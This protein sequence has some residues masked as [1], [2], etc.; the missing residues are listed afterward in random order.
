MLCQVPNYVFKLTDTFGRQ[1]RPA[2]R[3]LFVRRFAVERLTL[4]RKNSRQADLLVSCTGT[5]NGT[6]LG[7][8]SDAG[9]PDVN[10]EEALS[11]TTCAGKQ[12]K[13]AHT[14]DL[15][16]KICLPP[17]LETDLRTQNLLL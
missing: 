16:G 1:T 14:G 10:H 8:W 12:T 6:D 7:R 4:I 9:Q 3:A 5:L 11:E 13:S 2:V 15:A 17:N